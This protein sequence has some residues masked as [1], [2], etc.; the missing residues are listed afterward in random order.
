MYS[1]LR[2]LLAAANPL[3]CSCM[4]QVPART[5]KTLRPTVKLLIKEHT[6][7]AG[8]L[9]GC[10]ANPQ[11]YMQMTTLVGGDD[12]RWVEKCHL[13]GCNWEFRL[14]AI[15]V[16]LYVCPSSSRAWLPGAS[17]GN[18]VFSVTAANKGAAIPAY[19]GEHLG[20]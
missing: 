6:P 4:R 8:F 10:K 13:F 2:S 16:E 3:G 14:N 1:V 5:C 12:A 9:I 18:T 20:S 11:I 7:W 17:V 15:E 19:R